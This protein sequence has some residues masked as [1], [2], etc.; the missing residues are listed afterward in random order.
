MVDVLKPV[1]QNGPST[2][3]ILTDLFTEVLP[4]LP[5][6]PPDLHHTI[7][8]LFCDAARLCVPT[9]LLLAQL[10]R[11]PDRTLAAVCTARIAASLAAR[12]ELEAAQALLARAVMPPGTVDPAGVAWLHSS[13]ARAHH[14][15]GEG[16]AR[17]TAFAAAREAM[18]RGEGIPARLAFD[19]LAVE[20]FAGALDVV[21][22]TRRIPAETIEVLYRDIITQAYRAERLPVGLQV[23]HLADDFLMQ[24]RLL[25]GLV[26]L[27][28]ADGD[29][30][31]VLEMV[32]A[33]PV[34]YQGD[35]LAEVVPELVAHRLHS[36]A[37]EAV[38]LWAEAESTSLLRLG[39]AGLV[40]DPAASLAALHEA[41]ALR[42]EQEE[43]LG[44]VD[45]WAYRELG[46]ALGWL[47]E[48]GAA[49]SAL[50]RVADHDDRLSA[51]LNAARYAPAGVTEALICAARGLVA[52]LEDEMRRVRAL[53]RLG[54]LLSRLGR[55]TEAD[56]LFSE[57]LQLADGIRRPRSDQ[58]QTRRAALQLVIQGQLAVGAHVGAWL[59]GRK[60]R[61]RR[62]QDPALARSAA[63]YAAAGDLPG[64]AWC[65]RAIIS[66]DSR[67]LALQAAARAWIQ[68]GEPLLLAD[69]DAA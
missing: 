63:A 46:Q 10:D 65:V 8:D 4:A 17:D 42:L 1:G 30:G 43:E 20:D 67:L 66:L 33:A 37:R 50:E 41:L 21:S 51:L 2:T 31:S 44:M 15:L 35:L 39:G 53:M 60:L 64:A 68:A 19:L 62:H 69:S 3:P 7:A 61:T 14:A 18:R 47:G 6:A 13:R 24:H 11:L 56:A 40:E 45:A 12:G 36:A 25:R 22:S 16:P 52:S 48:L 59:A 9:P 5:A 29:G 34:A 49:L 38:A 54:M 26:R 58:G 55:R 32:R 23:L 27:P 57:A 28:L